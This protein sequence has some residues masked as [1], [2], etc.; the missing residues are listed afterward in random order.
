VN[1]LN[2]IDSHE[3][4]FDSGNDDT[5]G[6]DSNF[7]TCLISNADLAALTSTPPSSAD[8]IKMEPLKDHHQVSFV[9]PNC[10]RNCNKNQGG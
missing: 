4:I 2:A 10:A 1:R 3:V 9:T 6:S 5:P 7:E 8:G